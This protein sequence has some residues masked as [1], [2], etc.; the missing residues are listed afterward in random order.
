MAKT[1]SGKIT[2]TVRKKAT[3]QGVGGRSRSVKCS[4]STMNKHKKRSY[5]KYRGQGR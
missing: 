4:T 2:H 1:W 5:K 3:S